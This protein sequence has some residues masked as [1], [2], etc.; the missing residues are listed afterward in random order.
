MTYLNPAKMTTEK[1]KTTTNRPTTTPT[2]TPGVKTATT[3]H[4]YTEINDQ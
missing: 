3:Q 4:K 1:K 2:M